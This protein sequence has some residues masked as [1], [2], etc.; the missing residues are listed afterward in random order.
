MGEFGQLGLF[1]P[2]LLT[3]D[4]KVVGFACGR[5][6]LDTWLRDMALHNQLENYTRTFVVRNAAMEVK[7]YYAL[8]AGVLFRKDAPKALARHGSPAELPVALLARLAVH[9][10]VKGNGLG[11]ALLAHALQSACLAARQVALRAIMVD[12]LDEQAAE[13]YRRHHFQE[14][15]IGPLKLVLPIAD[16]LA[17]TELTE[18]DKG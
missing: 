8:C 7:G 17:S 4:H 3:R 15:K 2:E 10:D 16:V 12:A 9:N 6:A 1:S 5:P 14:T 11:Q 18:R 13:L